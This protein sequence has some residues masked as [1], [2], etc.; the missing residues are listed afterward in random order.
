MQPEIDAR[1][2]VALRMDRRWRDMR[3][4]GLVRIAPRRF[5]GRAGR[6]PALGQDFSF[7][8]LCDTGASVAERAEYESPLRTAACRY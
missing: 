3:R 1:L 8:T 5:A 2:A 6:L 4:H 7:M